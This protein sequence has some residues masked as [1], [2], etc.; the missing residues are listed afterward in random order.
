MAPSFTINFINFSAAVALVLN[1]K[2]KT[3]PKAQTANILSPKAA[4][5]Y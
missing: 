5:F 1:P 2:L 4:S 3:T